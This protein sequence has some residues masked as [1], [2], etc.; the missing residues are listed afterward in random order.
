M[1]ICT[2]LTV[3]KFRTLQNWCEF[4][5]RKRSEVIAMVLERVLDMLEEQTN[6]KQPVEHVVRRLHLDPP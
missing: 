6:T 5:Y 3:S 4:S 2:R 1:T